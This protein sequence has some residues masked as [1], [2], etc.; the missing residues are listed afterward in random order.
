MTLILE[1]ENNL[2]VT[3]KRGNVEILGHWNRKVP[4]YGTRD[5][6]VRKKTST[7]GWIEN[8]CPITF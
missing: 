8:Y 5:Y 1:E 6:W 2:T 7:Q 3:T 4:N